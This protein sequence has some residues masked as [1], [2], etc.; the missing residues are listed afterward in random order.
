MASTN[1]CIFDPCSGKKSDLIKYKEIGIKKIISCSKIRDDNIYEALEHLLNCENR[2]SIIWSHKS[3]YCSYTS[4]SRNT[5]NKSKKRKSSCPPVGERLL[6]S[7]VPEFSREDFK[8][9]CFFCTEECQPKNPKNPKRWRQW[10]TCE[11]ESTHSNC[12]SFKEV[13]LD[14]CDERKDDWSNHIFVRLQGVA[15]TLPAYD[16]RYHKDCY[17]SF[18]K[19][20]KNSVNAISSKLLID[21]PTLSVVN[22]L[23]ANKSSATWTIAELYQIYKEASGDLTRKQMLN[24]LSEHLGEELVQIHVPGYETEIGLKKYVRTT[25]KMARKSMEEDSEDVDDVVRR[26]RSEV[27]SIPLSRDYDLSDFCYDKAVK[28]TSETLLK[29]I[30][31]LVSKGTIDKKSL[32]LAQCIQQNI[33]AYHESR[34]NQTSLGLA[35]KLHHKTGSSELIRILHDHGITS[36]YDEVLRFRKSAASFVSQNT[37]D[38]NKILGLTTEI[39][40]IFSWCDN[41]DLWISS[42]NGMKATHAMVSEFTIHPKQV[43]GPNNAQ[44]GVMTMK[45]PRLKKSEAA[46]LKLADKSGLE[47]IHYNGSTKVK[48]PCIPNQEESVLDLEKLKKSLAKANERDA[49]FYNNLNG[50]D[51][52]EFSGYNAKE[53]RK[54][55]IPIAPKTL[56][57]FGPLLNSPPSHP[58][59]VLT[60]MHFLLNSLKNFG[61][62]YAHISMDMQLFM[63]ACK[64]KWDD[65]EAWK[66]IV[67]H[68]G[69]MHTLMSFLGCI[70]NLMKASGMETILT[71]TFGSIKGIMNGKTWPQALRAYRMLTAALLNNFLCNGPKTSEEIYAYL[72][73]E[74]DNPTKKLWVDCLIKPTLIAHRF[75]RSEREGDVLLRE[76][77]LKD[78]L[79]YF[80]AAGHHNYARYITIYLHEVKNL[81]ENARRDLIEGCNVCCHSN[82]APAVSSDQFGEQTYIKLGKGSGGLKGISTNDEQVA[83]WI[84]SFSICSHISL[85]LDEIYTSNPTEVSEET[86]SEGL[87]ELLYNR[88][89]KN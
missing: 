1:K 57:V 88:V 86:F 81:P 40:P 44:I 69:M 34:R 41:Y 79:P 6:K 45:I 28:D 8:T 20:P 67:I 43:L 14:L 87:D 75:I 13:L 12:I 11:K 25:L 26:I 64:I 37:A 17:D 31:M 42:P 83:V 51:P 39:G 74:E 80:F 63:I 18:R 66:D 62:E 21:K 47:I 58:D 53:D 30:S 7:Q 35:L 27:S 72:E 29:L 46:R 78:M 55:N 77:C 33:G 73:T 4:R 10:S 22:H 70:G 85:A 49:G 56:F 54:E 50:G 52:I 9:K 89:H 24:K 38:Y 32:T 3:C 36:S 84:N 68:P 19:T 65:L 71:T 59:T 16:G 60:T 82:G 23:K 48:P 76:K 5:T 61:M 15:T 2:E